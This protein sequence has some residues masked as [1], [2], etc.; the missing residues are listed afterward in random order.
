MPCGAVFWS[1]DASRGWNTLYSQDDRA[2]EWERIRTLL[3][4]TARIASTDFIHTRLTH[5]E[6]SYDYSDYLR[7]VN[8]YQPGVPPDTEYI[9]IDTTHPYSRIRSLADVTE[10][11]Q[12]PEA[13]EVLSGQQAGEF[14]VLRSSSGRA[15][16]R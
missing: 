7:A 9:A 10:L 4:L 2:A 1:S 16:D 11:Q 13:W 15:T 5:A 12:Q 14:I 8:N 6:R 3:P